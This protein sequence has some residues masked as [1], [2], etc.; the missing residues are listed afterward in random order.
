MD[1]GNTWRSAISTDFF[2]KLGYSLNDILPITQSSLNTAKEG[3]SLTIR[4]E[5]PKLYLKLAQSGTKYVFQ[6]LVIDKLGMPINISGPYMKT[7]SM[8]QIHSRN[9]IRINGKDVPLCHQGNVEAPESFIYALD[10]TLAKANSFTKIALLVSEVENGTMSAGDGVITGDAQFMD[11]TNLHPGI[12]AMGNCNKD[13]LVYAG[14]LNTLDKDI[15]V[16]R[17]QR[18]GT[19]TRTCSESDWD[20]TPWRICSMTPDAPMSRQEKNQIFLQKVQQAK[21]ASAESGQTAK[22]DFHKANFKKYSDQQKRDWIRTEF[23]LDDS[24]FLQQPADL[25]EAI[26]V[27]YEFWNLFSHDGSFGTTNILTHRIITED[28]PPIKCRYRPI[29]PALEPDLRKQLDLWLADNV[30]EAANS[31]WSFNLVAAKK[32]GD[33]IRWC[34]D[35]RLLVSTNSSIK[36]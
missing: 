4:G 16:P 23:N 30:I 12:H 17:G 8:D 29:N 36:S 21:K 32:K 25:Q 33:K 27:L 20:K 15:I 6:P 9:C 22:D 14:I 10:N 31:P 18:Y 5:S 13:G 35:W 1:S 7:H 24:P 34:V 26:D 11:N 19:F 28:V 2:L 3:D